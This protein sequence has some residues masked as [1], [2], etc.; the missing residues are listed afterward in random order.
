MRNV[1][2]KKSLYRGD[3]IKRFNIYVR[4]LVFLMA[5]QVS[6]HSC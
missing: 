6:K 1:D 2:I 4:N 3:A 5:L